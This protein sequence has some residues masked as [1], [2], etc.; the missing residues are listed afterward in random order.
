M[1][2]AGPLIDAH[3]HLWDLSLGKH[4]W[5][6]DAKRDEMVFGD[7]TPL[8]R[9]YLPPDFRADAERQNLVASVHVEAGW[10]PAD[11]VGETRWLERPGG[12]TWPADRFRRPRSAAQAGSRV[13]ASGP[14][15][16]R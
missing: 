4:P 3:H 14:A 1:I 5:L 15:P 10:D 9:N 13:G 6:R 2:Y 12:P 11:P 8:M 16:V 7:P